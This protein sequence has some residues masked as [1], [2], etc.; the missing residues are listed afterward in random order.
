MKSMRALAT[1]L[2]S[3][4]NMFNHGGLCLKETDS[5]KVL[6]LLQIDYITEPI[7]SIAFTRHE[8]TRVSL[9]FLFLQYSYVV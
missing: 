9:E 7:T 4:S 3:D 5:D 2:V 1:R 8:S 6:Q